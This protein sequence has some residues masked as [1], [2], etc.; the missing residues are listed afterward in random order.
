MTSSPFQPTPIR[1]RPDFDLYGRPLRKADAFGKPTTTAYTPATG[2]VPTQTVVT[3]P[4]GHAAT[5]TMEP[6]RGLVTQFTDANGKITTSEY[7]AVGRLTKVWK[8]TRPGATYKDS[9]SFAFEYSVRNDGPTVITSKKLTHDAK[10]DVSYTLHDGL[11]RERQSQRRSPDGAGRLLTETFYDTLGRPWR[12]S[13]TYYASGAPG[14]VLVTGKELDYTSSTD[15]EF[16]GAGRTTAVISKRFASETKRTS[17]VYTGD[18]TTVPPPR[19]GTVSTTVVDAL[20]RTVEQK[21]YT[22]PARTASQ[23]I[24]RAHDRHGRLASVTDPSNAKWTYTYDVRGRQTEINDPDKGNSKSTYDDADRVTDVRDARG[25]TLHTDFDV[26]GRRTALKKG[27]TKSTDTQRFG[28]DPL[29][30]VTEAWTDKNAQCPAAP[31]DGVVGGQDAYWTSYTYDAVGNRL[32]ETQHKTASGPVTD[33]LRTYAAPSPGKHDLP[34]VTQTGSAPREDLFTYDASGNTATRKI[35]AAPGQT[36]TWDD[37]GHLAS[38]KEGTTEKGSYVYDTDGQRIVR[39]DGSGTTLYLSHNTELHL[40]ANGTVTGTRYYVSDGA[41]VAFR[42]GGKLTFTFSDHHGTGTTQV[43]ADAAQTVTRRKT[44]PFG[45]QRGTKAAGWANDKGFLGGT[46]DGLTLTVHLGAREYDPNTGRFISVDP[47]IDLNDAQQA[48]GYS[49]SNNNPVTNSDPTGR[50]LIECRERLIECKNGP[51]LTPDP[52]GNGD[53]DSTKGVEDYVNEVLNAGW[54][55]APKGSQRVRFKVGK[56]QDRGIVRLT[57][58][59][60]AVRYQVHPQQDDPGPAHQCARRVHR[61]LR[62]GHRRLL[63]RMEQRVHLGGTQDR[64]ARRQQSDP[65]LRRRRRLRDQGDGDLGHGEPQGGRLPRHGGGPVPAEPVAPRHRHRQHG[66]ADGV[67]LRSLARTLARPDMDGQQIRQGVLMAAAEAAPRP[68]MRRVLLRIGRCAAAYPVVHLTAWVLIG[69]TASGADS[70]ASSMGIGL[71][72]MAYIGIPSVLL[73]VVSGLAHVRMDP[74]R[75]RGLLT[76]SL[77]VLALPAP[78]ASTP[79]PLFFQGLAQAVYP[80][81]LPAPLIPENWEGDPL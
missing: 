46:V 55:T 71:T 10:Y 69:L 26:L 9:P 24:K 80:L 29:R 36:L 54:G 22:D 13:G 48:H 77:L 53:G 62:R 73:A 21:E 41:A 76:V 20:G 79:E 60:R 68:G 72:T 42:T 30:R 33:T 6:L 8:P 59:I 12:N 74:V 16:D 17:T 52:P 63:R 39:R 81:L 18:T 28:L 11:L 43:T 32:T 66:L 25:V 64:C 45:A 35:G 1:V 38:V 67:R 4:K 23:S 75:Y 49:Y 61:H 37:E 78:A 15:T 58:S 51:V 34:K 19:G 2:E 3:N 57:L 50:M 70:F 14:P 27:A 5:T 65:H 31:S 44:T 56:G 47:V 7:D 40:A